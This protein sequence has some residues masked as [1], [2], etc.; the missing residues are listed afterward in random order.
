MLASF[1]G[2]LLRRPWQKS[3]PREASALLA[4]SARLLKAGASMRARSVLE[5]AIEIDPDNAEAHHRLGVAQAQEENYSGAAEHLG[6]AIAIN[7]QLIGAHVDLGNVLRLRGEADAAAAAYRRAL[8]LDRSNPLAHY[9]LG[10]LLRQ[11]GDAAAALPHLFRARDL[12]PEHADALNELALCL[13]ELHRFEE[14]IERLETELARRPD[15]AAVNTWLGFVYQKMLRATDAWECYQRAAALGAGDAEFFN[16]RGIVLQDL[17]RLEEALASY[18]HALELQPDYPL[19]R[20]HRGLVRL[21][22][23]DFERGWPDYEVRLVSEDN[24]QRPAR[25]PRWDGSPPSG[26]TILA[27][28]EQGLGDEMMFASCLHEII[29]A[30]GRLIIECAPKLE[31]LFRRSF[32]GATVY[33]ATPERAIPPPIAARN[34][35]LEIPTG[36][37][38]LFFRRG[39]GTFPRHRGYLHA[40]PQRI[41]GWRERLARLGPGL[42]VGISWQG[43]THKSRSPLRSIALERLEPVLACAGTRFVSLQYTDARQEIA[44]LAARRG[45]VVEHWPE[46]IAD[47]E[48]TAALVC[49]LDVVVSVCTAVIHLGGALGQRVLIMAPHSPEWRYGFAGESVPWYPSV[50]ILRQTAA[51]DWEPV[52]AA[53]AGVLRELAADPRSG[54]QQIDA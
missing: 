45:I 16:N 6:R 49:A 26:R 34:I 32:P 22:L 2:N 13:I 40:D 21:M 5:R 18:G 4:E 47:Y 48:H 50:R 33:A 51:G 3:R 46:A 42:K 11:A 35:D 27:W 43:G 37:L 38:P 8:E 12:M 29:D 53:V 10:L 39:P 24:P 44:E 30:G 23:G 19:A 31:G 9:N 20:F 41:A 54:R 17:G 15:S 1:L 52:I 14:A 28:G 7:A 25:Y 36:S